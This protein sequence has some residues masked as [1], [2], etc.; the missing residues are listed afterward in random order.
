MPSVSFHSSRLQ[1]AQPWLIYFLAAYTPWPKSVITED[2]WL[3]PSLLR[4]RWKLPNWTSLRNSNRNPH[5]PA[6]AGAIFFFWPP[7]CQCWETQGLREGE[8]QIMLPLWAC[9]CV[10]RERR[11][12]FG[13]GSGNIFVF[14]MWAGFLKEKGR[15]QLERSRRR[16]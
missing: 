10:S 6:K 4:G 14:E 11:S 5:L 12:W 7:F 9:M 15:A 13:R 16:N 1:I 8:L 3:P 2:P